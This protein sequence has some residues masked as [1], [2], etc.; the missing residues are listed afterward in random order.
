MTASRIGYF[1]SNSSCQFAID[2]TEHENLL[3]PCGRD[4]S[5]GYLSI[6]PFLMV[7]GI[8]VTIRHGGAAPHANDENQVGASAKGGPCPPVGRPAGRPYTSTV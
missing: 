8:F 3:S 4:K 2:A 6:I 7:S 1:L 5:E